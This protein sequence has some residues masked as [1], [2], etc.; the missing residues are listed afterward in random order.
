MNGLPALDGLGGLANVLSALGGGNGL[1]ALRGRDGLADPGSSGLSNSLVLRRL[2]FS[3]INFANLNTSSIVVSLL[4]NDGLDC[5][6]FKGGGLAL[7]SDF[8]G[9]SSSLKCSS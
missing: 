1:A 7:C 9:I 2:S 8:V 4:L 3:F 6:R 5:D